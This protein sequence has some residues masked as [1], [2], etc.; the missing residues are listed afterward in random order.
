MV[1]VSLLRKRLSRFAQALE[2]LVRR[3]DQG[4]A[5]PLLI[6][7]VAVPRHDEVNAGVQRAVQVLP[8]VLVAAGRRFARGC[9]A[10]GRG[11]QAVEDL[12]VLARRHTAPLKEAHDRGPCGD[13]TVLAFD[14]VGDNE[15]EVASGDMA[16]DLC[17]GTRPGRRA[18]DDRVRV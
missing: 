12:H 3:D 14:F 2:Q 17:G 4:A 9:D 11:A 13:S 1:L 16:K 6:E 5:D 10:F 18:G 8:V 15:R 7:E